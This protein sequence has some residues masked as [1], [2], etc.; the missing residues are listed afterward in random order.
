VDE[1]DLQV[2]RRREIYQYGLFAKVRPAPA[3]A[4][5]PIFPCDPLPR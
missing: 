3:P 1:L 2:E 4:L 5:L